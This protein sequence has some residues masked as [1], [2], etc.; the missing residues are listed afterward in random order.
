[1]V[2]ACRARGVVSRGDVASSP[3][4]SGW[5]FYFNGHVADIIS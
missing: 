2:L 5:A 1:M 4:L 3:R